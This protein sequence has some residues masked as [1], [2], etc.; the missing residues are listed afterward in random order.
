LI[1]QHFEAQ[2]KSHEAMKTLAN[3]MGILAGQLNRLKQVPKSGE[4]GATI[5]KFPGMMEEVV[6]FI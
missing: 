1:F 6:D 2:G 5:I 3:S 4:L